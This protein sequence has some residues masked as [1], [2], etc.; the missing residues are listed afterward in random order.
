MSLNAEE[1]RRLTERAEEHQVT[2]VIPRAIEIIDA[3]IHQAANRGCRTLFAMV[4]IESY[5]DGSRI[6]LSLSETAW[7][8]L[9]IHYEQMGYDWSV[10]KMPDGTVQYEL[11]W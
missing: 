9:Q 1:A 5:L 7:I 10:I 8:R 6:P 4:W 2:K 11:S 3:G